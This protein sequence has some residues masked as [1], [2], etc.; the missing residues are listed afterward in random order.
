MWLPLRHLLGQHRWLAGALVVQG[1]Q[2]GGGQ[3]LAQDEAA[4]GQEGREE[5]HRRVA[6]SEGTVSR[7]GGSPAGV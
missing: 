7:A 5:P 1:R 2:G 4:Q 3:R 6:A